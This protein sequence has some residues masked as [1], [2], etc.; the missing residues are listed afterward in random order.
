MPLLHDFHILTLKRKLE[1]RDG[2][3]RHELGRDGPA[4]EAWKLLIAAGYVLPR[5]RDA[6]PIGAA[7]G[8]NWHNELLAVPVHA[9]I[10][11]I[12]LY[13]SHILDEGLQVILQR[14]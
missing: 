8:L 4:D 11:L 10:N 1:H 6:E 9:D 3:V 14:V 13:L 12:H 7:L 5:L 2:I